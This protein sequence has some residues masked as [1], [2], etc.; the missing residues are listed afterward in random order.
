MLCY[1]AYHFSHAFPATAIQGAEIIQEEVW[2]SAFIMVSLSRASFKCIWCHLMQRHCARRT[3]V[4][5]HQSTERATESRWVPLIYIIM[6][7]PHAFDSL[8][9]YFDV[10]HWSSALCCS[11]SNTHRFRPLLKL[12]RD[13]F[14]PPPLR[15]NFIIP[16][17][18]K[19]I[20]RSI[21]ICESFFFSHP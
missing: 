8:W 2:S 7:A 20:L 16:I 17:Y 15:K 21:A 1:F 12:Q 9:R 18:F 11:K 13:N 19:S 3:I 10:M 14:S 4:V 6:T 5:Q